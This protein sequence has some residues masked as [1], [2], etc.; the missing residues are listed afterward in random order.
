V[1]A[2]ASFPVLIHN[3]RLICDVAVSLSAADIRPDDL[4]LAR[5][6][7]SSAAP[8][9]SNNDASAEQFRHIQQL[10]AVNIVFRI[11]V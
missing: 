9:V 1:F 5:R 6:P 4:I 11:K 2:A 3:R 10:S 8:P 7:S